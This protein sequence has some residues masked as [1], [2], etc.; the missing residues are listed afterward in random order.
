MKGAPRTPPEGHSAS[1]SS[2]LH[3]SVDGHERSTTTC[4]GPTATVR[5]PTLEGHQH[6]HTNLAA[7]TSV[8]RR[9]PSHVRRRSVRRRD[10]VVT[11]G[12]RR[13]DSGRCCR[14]GRCRSDRGSRRHGCRRC[15]G[16]DGRAGNGCHRERRGGKQQQRLLAVL[17]ANRG[18]VVPVGR[19]V[20]VLWPGED[21]P[22]DAVATVPTYIARLRRALGDRAV[23]RLERAISS[24]PPPAGSMPTSSIGWSPLLGVRRVEWQSRCMSVRCASC[25]A[26][27]TSTSSRSGGRA[28]RWNGSRSS[29]WS[30]PRSARLPRLPCRRARSRPRPER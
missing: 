18:R 27:R 11:A 30:R 5:P 2:P 17:A 14:L 13:R 6:G 9:R 26:V 1:S 20:E 12:G 29:A 10:V 25:V 3:R 19:L 28:T 22:V 23:V 7:A 24:T 8:R 4:L 15:T 21:G 16:G